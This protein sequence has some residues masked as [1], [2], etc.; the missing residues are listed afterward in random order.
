MRGVGLTAWH[1]GTVTPFRPTLLP[2]VTLEGKPATLVGLV[3]RVPAG[4]K[5]FPLHVIAEVEFGAP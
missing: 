5:L 3:G 4:Y 1:D 2:K